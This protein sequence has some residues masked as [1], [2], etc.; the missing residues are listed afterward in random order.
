MYTLKLKSEEMLADAEEELEATRSRLHNEVEAH[1]AEVTEVDKDIEASAKELQLLKHYKDKEFP[2]RQI[3]IEQLKETQEE[4][5]T[6]QMDELEDIE[7]QVSEEREQYQQH[8]EA[9]KLELETEAAEACM[10]Q[11]KKSIRMQAMQNKIMRKELLIH[12]K[13][14]HE[15]SEAISELKNALSCMRHEARERRKNNMPPVTVQ[16]K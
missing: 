12:Q 15:M 2:V 7:L 8:L 5:Q 11:V 9:K 6:S 14:Q 13:K 3:R 16:N 4:S 1:R 10:A